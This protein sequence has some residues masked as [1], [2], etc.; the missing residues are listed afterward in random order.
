MKFRDRKAAHGFREKCT[1]PN[2]VPFFDFALRFLPD[3]QKSIIVDVGA[4]RGELVEAVAE[5]FPN[6][7]A[8]DSNKYAVKR[9][10]KKDLNARQYTAPEALPFND[11]KVHFLHTSHMIEHLT[12][13]QLHTFLVEVDRVL[14]DGG[15]FV[16]SAPLLWHKFYDDLT[17]VRPYNPEAIAHYLVDV[18]FVRSA[19]RISGDF[20][21]DALVLRY[22][23]EPTSLPGSTHFSIDLLLQLKQWMTDKLG[24]RNYTPNGYTLVMTKGEAN[25]G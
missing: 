4:G 15:R 20:R 3:D 24:V 13:S 8:L 5:K 16:I 18:P 2:H 1:T 12:S 17:H 9:L 10:R 22:T 23:A 7:W 11:G 19:E 25:E 14:A 6:T 21:V